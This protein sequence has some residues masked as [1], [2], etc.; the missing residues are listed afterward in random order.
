MLEITFEEGEAPDSRAA[1]Q[2]NRE[3]YWLPSLQL[4]GLAP[5]FDI[6][7]ET[8]GFA[9]FDNVSWPHGLAPP[10]SGE[11]DE[12][13]ASSSHCETC[14]VSSAEADIELLQPWVYTSYPFDVQVINISFHL[15]AADLYT[16]HDH[17]A[18]AAMGV[19]AGN[20][21]ELL[22]PA[23]GTW[24]LYPKDDFDASVQLRHPLGDDGATPDKSRCVLSIR[25]QRNYM[26]YVVKRLVTD[27]LVVF[28]GLLCGLW[29][30]PDEMMGD[31]LAAILVALLIVVTSLQTDLGLGK[32]SY[33]IWVDAFNVVNLII[34][35][36]ALFE[37]LL[38][39]YHVEN[40]AHLA[41]RAGLQAAD[42]P[43][44]AAKPG[45]ALWA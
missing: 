45:A 29:L 43:R 39:H 8:A 27:V 41:E 23:T 7:P 19:T 16:C 36:L 6:V 18:L 25:V 20:A 34:L 31:R 38:V 17:D 10:G 40:Q 13:G 22:L 28:G 35:V 9:Y 44:M 14:V 1:K 2:A 11:G 3:L 5:K 30:V 21:Q 42:W 4:D 15:D 37:T 26:I 33:L 32:L 12:G 24:K